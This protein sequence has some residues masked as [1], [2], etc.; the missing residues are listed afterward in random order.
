MK[1]EEPRPTTTA[2]VNVQVTK[3]NNRVALAG[4]RRQALFQRGQGSKEII[5][6]PA[7]VRQVHR[8]QTHSLFSP[9]DGNSATEVRVPRTTT[10]PVGKAVGIKTQGNMSKATTGLCHKH[11]VAV[12]LRDLD[13]S[14]LAIIML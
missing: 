13:T 5:Q 3:E 6:G 11:N 7:L 2:Q 12:K 10:A 9:R 8:N 1:S 4:Q 14:G